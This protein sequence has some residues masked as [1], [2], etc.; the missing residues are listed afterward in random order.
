MAK[1][2]R[3]LLVRTI[4]QQLRFIKEGHVYAWLY[5]TDEKNAHYCLYAYTILAIRMV[6][7]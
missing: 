5:K 6:A 1:S 3:L 4:T 7:F 2:I